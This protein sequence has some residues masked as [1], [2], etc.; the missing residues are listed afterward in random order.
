MSSLGPLPRTRTTAA[1]SLEQAADLLQSRS[2]TVAQH[3]LTA[4]ALDLTWADGHKSRF[5]H[6][7]LRD[8]CPSVF[9]PATR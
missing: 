4:D 2:G 5:H 9:D 1:S 3:A 8:H 7:W 6:V